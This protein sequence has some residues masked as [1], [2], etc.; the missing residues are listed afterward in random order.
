MRIAI[1]VALVFLFVVSGCAQNKVKSSPLP[2]YKQTVSIKV[3]WR[4]N[5]GRGARLQLRHQAP[6][7]SGDHIYICDWKRLIVL[8]TKSGKRVW[9]KKLNYPLSGCMV[10]F[11]DRIYLSDEEGTVYAIDSESRDIIW[12]ND[13]NADSI[14][15]PAAN[16]NVVLIQTVNEKLYALNSNDGSQLWVYSAYNP[17]LTLFG[18]FQPIILGNIAISGFA[19][20]SVI[21]FDLRSG[22]PVSV[23]QISV[24]QGQSD[25]ER[26]V[27]IDSNA[28]FEKGI[29]YISSYSGTTI[30]LNL[31]S[32]KEVW[33]QSI[34]S[35][36]NM[37]A[38]E[39]QLFLVDKDS[40]I[41]AIDKQ[42]GSVIW[43]RDDYLYRELTAP[44]IG[45][46]YLAIG[47][48]K[49]YVHI[50]SL[51]DGST[52]AHK[53]IGITDIVNFI[54]VTLEGLLVIDKEGFA[55]MLQIEKKHNKL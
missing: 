14:G 44:V 32:G 15:P 50:L 23:R 30:A 17:G 39:D 35:F 42:D 20:G 13:I 53:K 18:S 40:R 29:L 24:P 49:G 2:K 37:A 19:D 7:E 33:R 12:Q 27:D 34:G 47:D 6:A 46:D 45:D 31:N 8:D 10:N 51:K 54:L 52:L 16:Q 41:Y 4:V 36:L 5:L 11:G 28:I 48:A 9:H 21:V 26:L 38:G 3:D 43:Q 25:I 22:N 1:S 55:T